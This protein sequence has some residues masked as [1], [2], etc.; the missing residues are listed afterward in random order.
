MI[1]DDHKLAQELRKLRDWAL[2]SEHYDQKVWAKLLGPTLD[3]GTT[4]CLAG[5][6]VADA[7]Y[8]F[9]FGGILPGGER[10]SFVSSDIAFSC[11]LSGE[12]EAESIEE[13]AREILNLT[14]WEANLLFHSENEFGM[15]SD[16][17]ALD[18]LNHLIERA[19]DA[20]GPM[21]Q[22]AANEWQEDWWEKDRED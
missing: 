9:L 6:V 17:M 3:C 12:E 5:K 19:E 1:R 16:Q 18:F 4:M 11:S 7:G 22:D 15:V 2:T 21:S 14:K 20:Q 13:R 10:L 8:T